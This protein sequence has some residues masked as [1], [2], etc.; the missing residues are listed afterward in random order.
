MS[1]MLGVMID[2]SRNAVMSVESVK[3][4]ASIIKKMG[5]NTLMLYTEDTYEIPEQP[6]F[7][8][9]RG[10]YSKDELKDIDKYC[11]EIGI[12]LIP[13]IQTLAHLNAMFKWTDEYSDINDCDDILIASDEK[14]LSLIDNML[15]N[16]SECF[17]TK[18]VHVGMDE[19]FR[20]G[21]G[22]YQKIHGIRDRFDIIN[23]H[24]HKVCDI[25]SKYDLEPMVWSDMF[26][27]LALGTD[28]QYD[29]VEDKSSLVEKAKLPKNLTLVYWDYISQDPRHCEK[30]I[31]TNQL[32]ERPVAYAAG[33]WTWRGFAPSNKNSIECTMRAIE[34]CRNTGVR[35]MFITIWGDDGNECSPYSVLPFLL[36]IAENLNGNEDEEAIKAKFKEI[37]GCSYDS[38]MLF[39][40]MDELVG[41]H[42]TEQN[43]YYNPCKYLLY[44][45]P[46]LGIR[47]AMC[48]SDDCSY[49][50]NL[51]KKFKEIS[52][53][54]DFEY[55]F[56]FYEKLCHVLS[57]KSD[58]G[59]RTRKAYTDKNYSELKVISDDYNVTVERIRELHKVHQIRWYKDNKPHGFDVQDIRIGGLIQ[60][61][62]S[63]KERLDMFVEGEIS[64]IPELEEPVINKTNGSGFW[65]RVSTPNII[66]HCLD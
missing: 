1:N 5:Y 20:I 43:Y 37:T 52:I 11:Q 50:E 56:N 15:K 14:V 46:F 27:T 29:V 65:W 2:C 63:C 8:H 33:A 53:K 24:L 13:C 21:T 6:L 38:F 39:D 9:L 48:S 26:T 62:T 45:D 55:L 18:K 28:N 44:N 61:L 64:S 42:N 16:I 49:Y 19:A 40:K 25:A 32:F 23:D 17:T 35:D 41:N 30:I 22:K 12:E 58:L 54:G 10:R 66:G 59:V 34:A 57:I 51:A 31:R 60:R 4:Y 3:K 7:G 36:T 47:D